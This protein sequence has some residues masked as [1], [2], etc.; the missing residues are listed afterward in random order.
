MA[1][2]VLRGGRWL[3]WSRREAARVTVVAWV[4]FAAGLGIVIATFASVFETTVVPRGNRSRF[5]RSLLRALEVPLRRAADLVSDYERRDLLLAYSAAAYVVSTLFAWLALFLVGYA[6]ILW[7]F[8]ASLGEAFRVAGSSMMTLG[9]AS[10]GAPVPT[11]FIFLCALTGLV[12][13]ALQ[14]AYLPLLY[15]A[16]NRR[17]TL[18]TMLE[19]LAGT[20]GWGPIILARSASVD[21]LDGLGDMYDRWMEWSADVAE[22]H[23]AYVVLMEFRSPTSQRSWVVSLLSILD[24]G[25]MHLALCPVSAPPQARNMMRI[26]YLAFR[27]LAAVRGHNVSGDPSPDG[28]IALTREEFL[29]ACA[30][31]RSAGMEFERDPEQAWPH[32]RGWRVN[33]EAA[34]YALAADLDAVPALWSGPRRRPGPPLPPVQPVDRISVSAEV[35][36]LRRIGVLRRERRR[37]LQA[38]HH[39]HGTGAPAVDSSAAALEGRE[40][41]DESG[42]AVDAAGEVGENSD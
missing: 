4:G 34:A 10:I 18:V 5:S 1:A 42:D 7:P 28:A 14:I 38:T 40:A 23:T 27:Q 16:Y 13:V 19:G 22:S 20:P 35:S 32:F 36:E 21:N 37:S 15:A 41:R 17:E 2:A 3:L 6:L 33:Y 30:R 8:A 29:D 11:A 26:G 24:A 39:E 25:A 12:V 9:I 31:L